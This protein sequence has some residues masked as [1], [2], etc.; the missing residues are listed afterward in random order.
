MLPFVCESVSGCV[1]QALNILV[2]TI[3]III[4]A[5]LLSNFIHMSSIMRVWTL[6]ILGH[7]DKGQ[8][9]F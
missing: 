4:F 7:G 6:L 9:Q 2:G 5:Q 8:G 1:C 3:Q